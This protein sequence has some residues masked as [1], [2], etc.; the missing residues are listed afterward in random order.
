[1]ARKVVLTCALNGGGDPKINPAIPITPAQIAA[2]AIL[3]ARSGA[4]MIHLHV[5][6]PDTGYGSMDIELYREA[7]G[8][9]RDAGCDAILNLTA[10]AGAMLAPDAGNPPN[11]APG[12][13]LKTTHERIRHVEELRPDMASLPMGTVN[14]GAQIYL[15]PESFIVESLACFR[16]AGVKP[17]LDVLDAGQIV[18][19]LSYIEKG[20]VDPRPVFQ[21][22]LGWPASAPATPEAILFMKSLL[23]PSAIWQAFGRGVG[24][25][26]VAAISILLGGNVRIGLEDTPWIS[27]GKLAPNNAALVE[28]TVSLMSMLDA[29]PASP[30]EARLLLG[31]RRP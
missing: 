26:P 4:A 18:S 21:F 6:D 7:V 5:R 10:G 1:M 11:V 2:D 29:E 8:R 14:R 28:K 30:A 13:T 17:E 22:C 20:L 15:N 16:A 3:A 25:F 9:I 19:A 27:E 31:L 23:P 12:A 24:C